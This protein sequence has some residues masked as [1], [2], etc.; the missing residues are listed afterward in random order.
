MINHL[1]CGETPK[2][3]PLG[4]PFILLLVVHNYDS[5]NS[6][7]HEVRINIRTNGKRQCCLTMDFMHPLLG[8]SDGLDAIMS[9]CSNAVQVPTW[10]EAFFQ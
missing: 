4:V 9:P 6:V 5:K 10:L 2:K 3:T 1:L 7:S 8:M